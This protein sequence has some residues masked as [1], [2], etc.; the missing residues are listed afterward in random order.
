MA[1]NSHH[2]HG[3]TDI[4]PGTGYSPWRVVPPPPP[5]PT[6][7]HNGEGTSVDTPS[8]ELFAANMMLLHDYALFAHAQLAD[9][10]VQPGVFYDANKMRVTINGVNDDD[11]VKGWYVKV[12]Y[13]LSLGLADLHDGILTISAKYTSIEDLNK[14]STTELQQDLGLVPGDFN[15][16]LGDIP[17]PGNGAPGPGPNTSGN[18]TGGS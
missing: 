13:D 10:N 17:K 7:T 18:N 11:G 2:Y 6:G 15:T 4:A 16:M 1:D 3:G 8:M 9:V 5:V 14:L 12:L